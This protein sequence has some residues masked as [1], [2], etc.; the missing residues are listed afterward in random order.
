MFIILT[1]G[2]VWVSLMVFHQ[3]KSPRK[4]FPEKLSGQKLCFQLKRFDCDE[5]NVQKNCVCTDLMWT[6]SL[7]LANIVGNQL[8]SWSLCS[9]ADT[10]VARMAFS[11]SSRWTNERTISKVVGHWACPWKINITL[12]FVSAFAY[13]LDVAW[14]W[15]IFIGFQNV[16]E[17]M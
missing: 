7:Y 12:R 10:C 11:P 17:H 5:S 9:Y 16:I 6:L 8:S 14:Q 2:S 15:L 3:Q 4:N 13:N 1:R